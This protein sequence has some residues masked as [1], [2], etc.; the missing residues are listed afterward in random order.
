MKKLSNVFWLALGLGSVCWILYKIGKRAVT[1]NLL[2]KGSIHTKAVII[3]ERNYMPNQPVRAGYSYSYLFKVDGVK[4]KGNSHDETLNIDDT[5]E[6]E[7]VA[8]HPDL[9]RPLHPKN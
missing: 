2:D 7:Y 3:S 9:N 5:V 8:G 6:I 4:Y 1:D